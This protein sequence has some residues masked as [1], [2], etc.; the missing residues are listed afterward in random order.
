MRKGRYI[1]IIRRS[2]YIRLYRRVLCKYY[3]T[4]FLYDFNIKTENKQCYSY[5]IIGTHI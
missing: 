1:F 4:I 3:V 5:Y 2:L